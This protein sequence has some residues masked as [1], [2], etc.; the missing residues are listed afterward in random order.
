MFK[1]LVALFR[2][3][4]HDMAESAVDRNVFAILNQQIRDCTRALEQARKA[5]AVA[6]AQQEKE[7][8]HLKEVSQRIADL[9]GRA[10]HAL[11]GGDEA[12]AEEAAEAIAYLEADREAGEEAQAT[13]A[14]EGERLRKIV[15]NSEAR[16]VE[17]RR[18]QKI[19]V[20][21]DKANRLRGDEVSPDGTPAASLAEAEQTLARLRERQED[22]ERTIGALETLD[23]ATSPASLSERMAEAGFGPPARV[24]TRD[25]L[26]RLKARAGKPETVPAAGDL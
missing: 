14:R 17:L 25:V 16:L 2:G 13:F 22:F 5:L 9:E 18:G 21:A 7:S 26:D 6:M 12:L 15:R 10:T 4:A 3:A 20:A 1:T 8:V 24:T 19:A 23:P 11:A